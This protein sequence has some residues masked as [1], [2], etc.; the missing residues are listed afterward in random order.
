[1]RTIAKLMMTRT[2]FD[3]TAPRIQDLRATIQHILQLD[4]PKV[5]LHPSDGRRVIHA[6][7]YF[8]QDIDTD[9]LSKL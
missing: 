3:P 6:L 4:S 1:M 9:K 8:V 5:I 2:I 7:R